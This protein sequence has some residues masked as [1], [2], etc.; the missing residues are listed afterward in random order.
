ML[1]KICVSILFFIPFQLNSLELTLDECIK[2][3]FDNNPELK[4]KINDLQSSKY[5][6]YTSLNS[7]LPKISFSH[8]F[9]RS[10][11]D[12]RKTSNS[13]SASATISQNIFDYSS[14]YSIK[15]SKINYELSELSYQ[16]Y[17]VDLRKSLYTAFYNLLFS[18]K[19]IEV[20]EKI[21][22]IRKNNY[23]LISLKYHSGF[24]SKGNMLYSK[25]QYE[26]AKVNLEKAKRQYESDSNA[27]K[28]IMGIKTKENIY[29]KADMEL[30]DLDFNI[31]EIERY[32]KDNIQYKTYLK[33]IE[34]AKEKIK[35]GE[36]D[37]FP[38]LS[39]S[40][41][42]SVTGERE[43]PD[44]KSW[45][46][47]ISLSLPLFSG[48]ITYRKNNVS[49]LKETLSSIEQKL[50]SYIISLNSNIENGYKD[51]LNAYETAKVYKI[52]LEANEERYKEAQ[53]KYM[54]GKM[55]YID[56]E[57]IEENLINAK[58][59]YVD[60]LKNVYLRKINLENLMSK[61]L[62]VK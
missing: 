17:L 55:S 50:N 16:A 23:E 30:P 13:F 57:N 22:E 20:N 37:W 4:A 45:N 59:T 43:F 54:A 39:F 31:N 8:S 19:M 7:Y 34:L 5:S 33:N 60:Y 21:V 9:S 1:K 27:L 11:G 28:S 3:T 15:S 56:L 42:S 62:E 44:K 18:Q 10:G 61:K 25:A 40:A 12:N 35:N 32:V 47:G 36:N 14:I 53:I 29:V 2:I 38:K 58:R 41:S 26:M 6:Y 49:M 52:F 46:L 51:F 24:E 48:G